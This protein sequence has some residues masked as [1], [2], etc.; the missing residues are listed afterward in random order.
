MSKIESAFF[1][2]FDLKQIKFHLD[3]YDYVFDPN[4]MIWST[5]Y[6]ERKQDDND[7]D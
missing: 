1:K 3:N 6:V 7:D 4:Y 2:P 5:N